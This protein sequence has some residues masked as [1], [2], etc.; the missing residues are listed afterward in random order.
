M[1]KMKLQKYGWNK[2]L[3]Y[4][5]IMYTMGKSNG[6]SLCEYVWAGVTFLSG[7][8]VY[9][10]DCVV[11]AFIQQEWRRGIRNTGC[12]TWYRSLRKVDSISFNSK[13][14]SCKSLRQY[15]TYTPKRSSWVLIRMLNV[16]ISLK[17]SFSKIPKHKFQMSFIIIF[18]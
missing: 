11:Y 6:N 3:K 2:C 18:L 15:L 14:I 10:C 16:N 7:L 4:I 8:H 12:D 13:Y 17:L 5:F 1:I 9:V